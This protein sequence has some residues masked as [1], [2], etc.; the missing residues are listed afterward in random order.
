MAE[1]VG[2]AG[3][4]RFGVGLGIGALGGPAVVLERAHRGH[5]H[6]HIGPQAIHAALDI[7]KLF[8]AQ[9]R[10]E[11][12]LR[13]RIVGHPQRQPGGGHAVAAV[14]DVGEGSAMHQAGV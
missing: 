1:Q 8:R 5:Q 9:V 10:A 7:Q 3:L 12:R 2:H 14:R 4:E 11:A 13:H 6:D